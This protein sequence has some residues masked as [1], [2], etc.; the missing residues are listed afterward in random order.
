MKRLFSAL[1][2]VDTSL[3]FLD[4]SFLFL[5]F[6]TAITAFDRDGWVIRPTRCLL[7]DLVTL[8]DQ[9]GQSHARRAAALD[10]QDRLYAIPRPWSLNISRELLLA[11]RLS[12]GL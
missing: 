9:L 10:C 11:N 1:A 2:F 6:L 3:L 8:P 5:T 4:T 12:R 7:A